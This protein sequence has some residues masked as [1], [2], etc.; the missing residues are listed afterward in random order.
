MK[1]ARSHTPVAGDPQQRRKGALAHNAWC[2][3][4]CLQHMLQRT[5]KQWQACGGDHSCTIPIY[6]LPTY[7]HL[8]LKKQSIRAILCDDA[9]TV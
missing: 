1:N 5:L 7:G 6:T 3:V 2:S 8:L 4:A 9:C